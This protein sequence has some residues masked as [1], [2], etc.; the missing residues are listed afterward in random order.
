MKD[1]ETQGKHV[2][3]V[4]IVLSRMAA[5]ISGWQRRDCRRERTL[6]SPV[7]AGTCHYTLVRVHWVYGKMNLGIHCGFGVA[8][9]SLWLGSCHTWTIL[10]DADSGKA[11]EKGRRHGVA[12]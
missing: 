4:G 5:T 10:V 6:P 1:M 7:T 11:R 8:M 9:V 3:S 2:P 12:L